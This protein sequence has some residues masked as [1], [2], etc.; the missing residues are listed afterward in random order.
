MVPH[1]FSIN[2]NKE[3][4]KKIINVRAR[5]NEIHR[6]YISISNG[7][8]P[9]ELDDNIVSTIYCFKPNGEK[10]WNNCKISN[11]EVICDFG[12]DVLNC[13]GDVVC[14]LFLSTL[15]TNIITP[16]FVLSVESTLPFPH[17]N[18]LEEQPE[19]WLDEADLYYTKNENG[20]FIPVELKA[21][22]SLLSN[23]E[24]PYNKT[25][26][27]IEYRTTGALD[28]D[29]NRKLY[30]SY[31]GSN[32]D[33]TLRYEF[34][35]SL[36][37]NATELIASYTSIKKTIEIIIP[38]IT[39]RQLI[40]KG[41]DGIRLVLTIP[42]NCLTSEYK[43]TDWVL[44]Y[45]ECS[46]KNCK[47]PYFEKGKYYIMTNDYGKSGEQYN[48]LIK[49][50]TEAREFYN[51]AISDIKLVDNCLTIDFVN[52]EKYVSSSLKGNGIKNFAKVSTSG[53]VDTYE[54][55]AD[56]GDKYRFSVTNTDNS[57]LEEIKEKL[58]NKVNSD[59]YNQKIA[60]IKNTI[61][62]LQTEK[63]GTDDFAKSV[64]ELQ[65]L[66]AD[67]DKRAYVKYTEEESIVLDFT[68]EQYKNGAS[69]ES[70]STTIYSPVM[71]FSD[72]TIKECVVK[73]A[74]SLKG[75]LYVFLLK[76]T[77]DGY[78]IVDRT[79]YIGNK[80]EEY[81]NISVNW[82]LDN[83]SYRVGFFSD[84]NRSVSVCTAA[85][86]YTSDNLG[87]ESMTYNADT[88]TVTG[89]Q[90]HKS[91]AIRASIKIKAKTYYNYA[92]KEDLN[93]LDTKISVIENRL[94]DY[95]VEEIERVRNV[96]ESQDFGLTFTFATDIHISSYEDLYKADIIGRC[97]EF[98]DF[99]VLNGDIIDGSK[100]QS[101]ESVRRLLSDT[102]KKSSIGS[103]AF[104]VF[105]NHDDNFYGVNV[106]GD[107]YLINNNQFFNLTQ[108]GNTEYI[109]VDSDNPMQSWYYVDFPVY[110]IRA[111]F[112]NYHAIFNHNG[113]MLE[114]HTA[115][116]N[117]KIPNEEIIWLRDKAL[118]FNDKPDKSEWAV[119]CFSHFNP[120]VDNNVAYTNMY[121]CRE[122]S[123]MLKAFKNGTS[124]VVMDG[125]EGY[126]D[127]NVF[128]F[129]EQG[130]M[131]V[132]CVMSGHVHYDQVSITNDYGIPVICTNNDLNRFNTKELE[133][134]T[135]D[136]SMYVANVPERTDG[137]ITTE[138]FDVV[139]I[140]RINKN[141]ICTRYGAGN[142]RIVSYDI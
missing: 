140:D 80:A 74:F 126:G 45:D 99:V 63:V 119:I 10:I 115:I 78:S 134:T 84:V 88:D 108:K 6:L 81:F 22:R 94:A 139:K 91:W 110:K 114:G 48:A 103:P 70:G 71:V 96:S 66:V 106:H 65:T 122:F 93:T 69:S 24:F 105:G 9:V 113:E 19:N 51:K 101:V 30:I 76:I 97:G 85:Y 57:V 38:N 27:N 137:T 39:K 142:S 8:E 16:K 53:N 83:A 2:L 55:V 135:P 82:K 92:T 117:F 40:E 120:I 60:E 5:D 131:E 33:I 23:V 89:G 73:P 87:Y 116:N 72:C 21:N 56:N 50:I 43:A 31:Y 54:F 109:V 34:Y 141:I 138:S 11:N 20:D 121:N 1:R 29:F 42:T 58:E 124:F 46:Y 32:S 52:G 90:I 125:N 59:I 133:T 107:S 98:S 136:T 36:N 13:C 7:T 130:P 123:N 68:D 132:I 118:R 18:L 25:I 67:V 111:I 4:Y 86:Q 26:G 100:T 129:T 28:F 95:Y 112:I 15:G 47:T 3:G 44:E 37:G 49:A 127:D 77:D 128:D 75:D 62:T 14:E 35:Y 41:Y 79:H 61:N 102:V 12:G 64:S 17:F 104:S